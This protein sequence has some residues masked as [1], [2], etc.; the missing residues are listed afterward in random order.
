M[1]IGLIAAAAVA[2]FASAPASAQLVQT[3]TQQEEARCFAEERQ[4]DRVALRRHGQRTRDDRELRDFC[5]AEVARRFDDRVLGR[6]PAAR[7]RPPRFRDG[8]TGAVGT[9]LGIHGR[10]HFVGTDTQAGDRYA[11]FI[12]SELM[13]RGSVASGWLVSVYEHSSPN[14]ATST[15]YRV[16][17]ECASLR[18]AYQYSAVRDA[19]NVV[20]STPT[21]DSGWRPPVTDPG[22]PIARLGA[23]LCRGASPGTPL[24]PGLALPAQSARAWFAANPRRR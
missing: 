8:I 9:Q 24:P 23:A 4:A 13:E 20:L 14:G 1:R 16:Q 21:P 12:E 10:W 6:A 15:A 7:P 19:G 2:A 11:Y 3:P 17:F 5:R 18:W 22:S